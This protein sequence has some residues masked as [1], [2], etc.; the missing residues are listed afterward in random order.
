VVG[1]RKE[2]KS[3]NERLEFQE[4]RIDNQD[5]K[6]LALESLHLRKSEI[7]EETSAFDPIYIDS[8]FST[9]KQTQTNYIIEREKRGVTSLNS[10]STIVS[11][12]IKMPPRLCTSLF[13]PDHP[14]SVI[15]IKGNAVKNPANK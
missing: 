6:I 14:D 8:S 11:N 1:L 9:K 7:N 4:K 5:K 10:S 13:D 2:L 3:Q 15:P 12:Y